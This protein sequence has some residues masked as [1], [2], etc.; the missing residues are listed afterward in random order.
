M[1]TTIAEDARVRLRPEFA[2]IPLGDDKVLLRSPDQAVRV[3][4]DGMSARSLA[5]VLRSLDGRTLA[6]DVDARRSEVRQLVHGLLKREIIEVD[7]GALPVST[8]ERCFARFHDDAAACTRRLGASRVLVRGAGAVADA[9]AEEFRRAG[10]GVV[11]RLAAGSSTDGASLL[12]GCLAADLTVLVSDIGDGRSR[13]EEA[14]NDLAVEHGFAWCPVRI[15]GSEGFV[16]PLF[17][18][19]E[20]PCLACLLAREEANWVEPDVTRAYLDHTRATPSSLEAYGRLPGFI[21]IVNAW[22]AIE[23]TKYLSRF[24][25]P[26][27]LGHVMRI[28]VLRC[29]TRLHRVL[30]L[31]RCARCSPLQRRPSVN[32]LLYARRAD[33]ESAE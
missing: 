1:A 15:F 33:R 30:R 20:G 17:V 29:A 28:D 31:P 25:T 19:G 12:R 26:A 9:L 14:V 24:T 13:E 32:S 23:G 3:S 8:Q 5:G 2:V 21:T 11:T 7:P 6:S 18:A 16:G 22:A 10:V 4:V 27:I